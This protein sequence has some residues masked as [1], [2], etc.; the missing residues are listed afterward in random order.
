[1]NRVR[2][3]NIVNRWKGQAKDF[4][5]SIALGDIVCS[6]VLRKSNGPLKHSINEKYYNKAKDIILQR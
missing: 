1:M 5:I 6:T 3:K 4:S 2:I